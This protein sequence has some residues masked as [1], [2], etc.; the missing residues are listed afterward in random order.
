MTR[1]DVGRSDRGRPRSSFPPPPPYVPHPE[2]NK[3]AMVVAISALFFLILCFIL[4]RYLHFFLA[5][6]EKG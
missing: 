2:L 5:F 4:L 6:G 3:V 1:R